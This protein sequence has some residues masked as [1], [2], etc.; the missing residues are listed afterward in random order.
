[1]DDVTFGRAGPYGDAWKAEPLTYN[2]SSVAIPGRS[3]MSMHALFIL[4]YLQA[5]CKNTEPRLT[6][7]AY[8]VYSAATIEHET[9]TRLKLD[10]TVL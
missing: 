7:I 4:C 1:M 9:Y 6:Y 5:E 10:F 8:I 2:T 3:L